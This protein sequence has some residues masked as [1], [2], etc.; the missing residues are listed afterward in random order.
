MQKIAVVTGSSSGIGLLTAIELAGEG[1]RVV[2]TMRELGR[3]SRL[4]EAAQKAGVSEQ[5]RHA[6]AR[7]HRIST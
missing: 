4:E 1:Y 3:S 6:P 5:T 7:R 2:A